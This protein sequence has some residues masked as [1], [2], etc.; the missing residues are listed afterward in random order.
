MSSVSIWKSEAEKNNLLSRTLKKPLRGKK[1]KKKEKSKERKLKEKEN[2]N[3]SRR[4][5]I[6]CNLREIYEYGIFSRNFFCL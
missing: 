3:K 5:K 2:K 6:S 1:K 4:K